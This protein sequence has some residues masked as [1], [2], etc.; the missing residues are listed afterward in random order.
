M[1]HWSRRT[2]SHHHHHQPINVPI[3]GAHRAHW[4]TQGHTGLSYGSYI[5]TTGHNP[6]RGPSADWWE[7]YFYV[8]DNIFDYTNTLTNAQKY[9]FTNRNDQKI[10]TKNTLYIDT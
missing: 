3:A 10:T 9:I 6:P 4:G 1:I 7:N 5:R 8:S 2:I